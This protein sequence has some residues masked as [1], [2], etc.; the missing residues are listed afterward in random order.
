MINYMVEEICEHGSQKRKCIV[1]ESINDELIINDLNHQI[2]GLNH[3]IE[4]ARLYLERIN[5]TECSKNNWDFVE[6]A[7]EFLD[8]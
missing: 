6:N 7:K 5:E 4:Q 3:N 1:C 8:T 2:E